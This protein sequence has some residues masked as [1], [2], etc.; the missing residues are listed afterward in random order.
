MARQA[1]QVAGVGGSCGPAL[2]GAKGPPTLLMPLLMGCIAGVARGG[3]GWKGAGD[4]PCM[5]VPKLPG[6]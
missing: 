5:P 4:G 1:E 6:R 2:C 3:Y